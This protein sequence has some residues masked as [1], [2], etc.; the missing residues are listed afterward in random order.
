MRGRS[1]INDLRI[2]GETR[3]IRAR[4]GFRPIIRI[5]RPVLDAVRAQPAVFVLEGKTLIL[6]SL[7][8]IINVR[9]LP[10]SQ[11][12]L[13]SCSGANLT[14]RNC[15]ITLVN[16]A[17]QPFTLIRAEGSAARGSRIRLEGSLIRGLLTSGF[18]LASGSVD[19]AMRD[20]VFLG[21]QGPIVAGVG[22][23][24]GPS[25]LRGRV[26]ARRSRPRSSRCRTELSL[27]GR[28]RRLLTVRSFDTA[29]GRF[30]GA[31]IA[32]VIATN[33]ATAS[34]VE[35]RRLGRAGQPVLRLEG[36][37]C[38][39]RG[40]H[41][42][43]AELASFRSTWNGSDQSSQEILAPWPQP[44]DL[45]EVVPA[46]LAPFL[47]IRESAP[48]R[49]AVPTPFLKAKTIGTFPTP[50]VPLPLVLARVAPVRRFRRP[51]TLASRAC[52][53]GA[54]DYKLSNESHNS[55]LPNSFPGTMLPTSPTA[56]D[57]VFD[58]DS[59]EWHATPL[60]LS[61]ANKF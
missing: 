61:P 10:A 56:S 19:V 23:G 18:E 57:F 47:P 15:T 16:P 30:Q 34:P 37:L 31:G 26:R 39:R 44:A 35:A 52:R 6:D 38:Q 14:L 8:I 40:T 17:N 24:G 5:D 53:P 46:D 1:L 25:V 12:C 55:R 42:P 48:D 45:T 36:I 50:E 32:S 33:N 11:S 4:A 7:D 29:F 41:D 9:D 2:P 21:S 13:F 20:T 22:P 54:L 49:A 28:D 51:A 43:G 27:R 60:T 3:L 59:A 58:A